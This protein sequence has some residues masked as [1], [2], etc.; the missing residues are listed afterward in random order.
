MEAISMLSRHVHFVKLQDGRYAVY[1]NLVMDVLYVDEHEKECIINHKVSDPEA[2]AMLSDKGIYVNDESADDAA[3]SVLRNAYQNLVGKIKIMYLILTN[4]CN[5]NCR[6][7]FLENNPHYNEKRSHM[8]EEIAMLAVKK[9]CDYLKSNSIE[10]PLIV[11][12]GGEPLINFETIKKVICYISTYVKNPQYSLI[13]NGTLL[14]DDICSFLK[15]YNVNVGISIDGTK[16]LHDKNRPFCRD[17]TGSF[18]SANKGRMMLIRNRVNYGLSMTLSPQFLEH[19]DEV[20]K[21]LV[22]ENET[23]IFYNLYHFSQSDEKWLETAESTVEFITKSYDSFGNSPLAEG[24][25]QRQIDSIIDNKFLFSDC[26][27]IG[28]EQFVVMPNGDVTICHGDSNT[29]EHIVGN[30]H[31]IDIASI[32]YSEEGAQWIKR[33]TLYNDDCLSC[34]ALFCCGGGCKQQA[35]NLFGNREKID[36]FHCTYVKGVLKW[37]LEKATNNCNNS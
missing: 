2:I 30:I 25:I 1:N 6:Y 15:K 18:D 27:A 20:M 32:V 33:A 9:Y 3:L 17:G 35:Q 28:C 29:G 31:D 13:T 4:S 22:E 26:G 23:N 36:N 14:T 10:S 24:R 21:W 19:Q 16:E 5:L 34:E 11:L 37:I 12:Y 8:S 7:C